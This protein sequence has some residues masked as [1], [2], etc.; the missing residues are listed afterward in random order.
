MDSAPATFIFRGTCFWLLLAVAWS[1]AAQ[2][3]E[4]AQF[5][6]LAASPWVHCAFYRQYEIDPGTG[7]RLLVEGASNS[8]THYQRQYGR[9]RSIDTRRSGARD[10]QMLRGKKYLHFIERSAGLY[11]VTTIYACLERDAR[12]DMCISYGAVN[13]RHFDSRVLRDPDAVFE[14]LQAHAEPGFCDHSF[15]HLQEAARKPQQR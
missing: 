12:S 8:L 15:L 11:T 13:A 3:S 1:A 6:N 5:E 9:L 4:V 7:N 2:Q 10:A 14:E